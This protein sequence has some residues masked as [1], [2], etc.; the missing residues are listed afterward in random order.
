MAGMI[1]TERFRGKAAASQTTSGMGG[2]SM[3]DT[4]RRLSAIEAILAEIKA[5][6]T[7][8]ATKTELEQLRT[9][10]EQL[11]GDTRTQLEQLRGEVREIKAV[12]PHLATKADV[13]ATKAE[14]ANLHAAMIKWVVGTMIGCTAAAYSVARLFG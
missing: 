12:L 14:I 9:G 3:D 5:F 2:G 11:R 6:L 8:V 1:D 7:T 13:V 4:Q 10:L